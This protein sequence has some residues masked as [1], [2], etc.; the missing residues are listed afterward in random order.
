MFTQNTVADTY[1]KRHQTIE[2]NDAS[3]AKACEN[4]Q[5]RLLPNV[6]N[7]FRTSQAFMQNSVEYQAQI[8]R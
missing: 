4:A 1:G 2:L 6:F 7:Q 3:F 8:R 5:Y